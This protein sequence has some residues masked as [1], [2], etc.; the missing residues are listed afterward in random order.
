MITTLI[1]A[2]QSFA[3]VGSQAELGNQ[4]ESDRAFL[5]IHVSPPLRSPISRANM[6]AD[7]PFSKFVQ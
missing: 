3:Q 2:K 6:A 7:A 1:R 4:I 5:A